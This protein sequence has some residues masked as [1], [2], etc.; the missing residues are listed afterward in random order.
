MKPL[1]T[2]LLLATVKT[3]A[4]LFY[5]FDARW[6]GWSR[7]SRAEIDRIRIIVLL[8]HT[9]LW[10][11]IFTGVAPGR[12]L[13]RLARGGVVPVADETMRRLGAG[14]FF[15]FVGDRVVPISRRRDG[16]WE[17]VLR[18]AT[19]ERAIVVVCPEGRML[20]PTGLDKNGEPMRLRSGI[21]DVIR[22][23]EG[24][25][26]LLVYSGGLHHVA[27]PNQRL[28]RLFRRIR[29]R[30]ELVDIEQYRR[31]M[32]NLA[33]DEAAFRNLV[34]QD[35]TRRRN[36]FCPVA[37]SGSTVPSWARKAAKVAARRAA[38]ARLAH[39]R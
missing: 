38:R 9:S 28:P 27:A 13:W 16:T 31:R 24:G 14:A 35:L 10:E 8:N 6:L 5:R 7:F 39:A 4:R 18:S 23:S 19:H 29:V 1:C 15:R 22:C 21:A 26:M 11:A 12:L 20:R 32:A 30:L 37:G 36:E 34:V 2:Y 3:F 17:E 33:H 25:S